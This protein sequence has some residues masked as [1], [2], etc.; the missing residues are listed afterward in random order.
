MALLARDLT[1]AAVAVTV[2]VPTRNESPNVELL[3]ERLSVALGTDCGWELLF[4]DDSDDDTPQAIAAQR[5]AQRSIRLHHRP[6]GQRPGGLGGAV[7]DGFAAAG[8]EVIVVMDADLQHPPEVVPALVD[9]IQSG[10]ADLV[11]GTRYADAGE[12]AGLSGPWRRA[13]SSSSRRLVHALIPRSRPLT[14]P[15]SG[16]FAFERSVIEGVTLEANGF[17]ILLE[18]VA[19][20]HWQ[21]AVNLAYHFDRRH[22]GRSKASLHE[23]WLF[24]QHLARLAQER[25]YVPVRPVLEPCD[26]DAAS[27]ELHIG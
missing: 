18:V 19:R 20:G 5:H 9:V 2:I 10:D 27:A 26:A 14:D 7:Q 15:L 4:V 3:V 23:G 13:V 16:L 8:G 1:A 25:R 12:S 17:K 11:V 24:S 21:R 6:P 22:A